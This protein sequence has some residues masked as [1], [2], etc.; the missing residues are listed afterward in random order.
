MT[1]HAEQLI[2]VYSV[3]LRRTQATQT[4]VERHIVFLSNVNPKR[5]SA[6]RAA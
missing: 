1:A 4:G 2:P 3:K 5:T 6:G